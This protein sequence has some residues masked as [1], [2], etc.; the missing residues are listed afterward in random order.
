MKKIVISEFMDP[1]A[2][3]G[4]KNNFEVVYDPGLVDQPD[5]LR[6]ELKTADAIIVRNRTQVRGEL[7]ACAEKLTAVGRLGV[8]LDNI[9][10][11]VC[12]A[13]Q[14]VV[15]PAHGA[16]KTAVA[17]Y[18]MASIF[19]LLRSVYQSTLEMAAG[20]W[21]R[22]ALMGNETAGKVLGV[23]GYG[24]IGR[25][26]CRKAAA[27][28]MQAVAYH[29]S[30]PID[31]PAWQDVISLGFNELL[32]TADVISLHLP[33]T[34]ETR[35]MIDARAMAGMKKGALLINTARGGVVDENAL[36]SAMKSGQ[37]GGAAIDVFETEPLNAAM[38]QKFKDL[39]N[40]ILTPHIAGVT[41]ESNRRVSALTAENISKA[42]A[43]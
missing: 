42:L 26:T 29:P 40:L 24:A 28:G 27:M 13:R 38:G 17:E 10:L 8:G 23:I 2:I 16:N 15:L 33:L 35:H 22:T 30:L 7:L 19:I 39:P 31:D 41:M 20:Q 5:C 1:A 37:I 6:A 3:D 12:K 21:P 4:L 32:A 11:D 14:I 36:V 18:V 25:E 34:Q 43:G 9:D